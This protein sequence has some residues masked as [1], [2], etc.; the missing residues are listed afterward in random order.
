M[1]VIERRTAALD[2]RLRR[3]NGGATCLRVEYLRRRRRGCQ[4]VGLHGTHLLNRGRTIGIQVEN[5]HAFFR[6]DLLCCLS[7]CL[8]IVLK[9]SVLKTSACERCDKYRPRTGAL[10]FLNILMKVVREFRGQIR[11]P[12]RLAGLIVMSELKQHIRRLEAGRM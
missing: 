1:C 10:Y 5:R 7:P 11:G 9:F 4:E 12:A 6:R 3:R 2:L 8:K